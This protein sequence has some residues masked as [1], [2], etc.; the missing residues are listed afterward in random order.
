M[1]EPYPVGTKVY[2]TYWRLD[3]YG[4]SREIWNVPVVI[5]KVGEPTLANNH[6]VMSQTRA[7]VVM[8][9]DG[10]KVILSERR[11]SRTK[12]HVEQK[13]TTND[14]VPER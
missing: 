11:L 6:G 3:A 2:A 14:Q 13:D 8:T 9:L 12:V 1:S 7:Y 4:H 10:E 5:V